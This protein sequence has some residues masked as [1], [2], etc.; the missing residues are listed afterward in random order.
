M[1][2]K[3][4]IKDCSECS[5]CRSTRH[6]TADSFETAFDYLCYNNGKAKMIAGYVDWNEEL[7]P[8]PTWCP[9]KTK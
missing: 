7:P 6:Y 3:I 9:R 1:S 4:S 5:D 2:T 8:V